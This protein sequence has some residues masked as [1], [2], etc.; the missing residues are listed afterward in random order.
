MG[1][2]TI[3]FT[4]ILFSLFFM[5]N[6]LANGNNNSIIFAQDKNMSRQMASMEQTMKQTSGIWEF[7][8]SMTNWIGIFSL[9][10]MSALLA[11]KTNNSS[12]IDSQRRRIIISI[13]ILSMAVGTIHILLIHEHI[14]ASFGW[15][16][17]FLISGIAQLIYGIIIGFV[18]KP[19]IPMVFYYIGIIGNVI[20]FI[21]FILA[22]LVTPP[23]SPEGT[24]EN[25]LDP[26]GIITLIIE[27]SIVVLLTFTLKFKEMRTI[28]K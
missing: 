16:M 4:V 28:I 7:V 17:F 20:M 8:P 19:H 22:R 2:R 25:E 12:N 3:V 13:A 26:N 5:S 24:P 27:A 9:G 15:G 1:K 11:F 6:A 10:M 14:Q 18:K 21:I 23:F